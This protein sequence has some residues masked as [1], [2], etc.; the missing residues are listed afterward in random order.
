MPATKVIEKLLANPITKPIGRVLWRFAG[1]VLKGKRSP[2]E[3]LR[4]F[5]DAGRREAEKVAAKR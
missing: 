2:D 3:R 5:D 1:N 4:D